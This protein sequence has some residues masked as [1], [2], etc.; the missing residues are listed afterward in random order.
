VGRC[1]LLTGG[2]AIDAYAGSDAELKAIADGLRGDA[3]AY[4]HTMNAKDQK[5][6]YFQ[7]YSISMNRMPDGK[8]RR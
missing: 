1:L 5:V 2:Q 4:E 3:T 7:S 6:R 8:A